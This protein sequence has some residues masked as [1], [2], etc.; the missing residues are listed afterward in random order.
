MTEFVSSRIGGAAMNQ[1]RPTQNEIGASG[2]IPEQW[3][4][5]HEAEL[6]P[7]L[8]GRARTLLKHGQA[9][10]IFR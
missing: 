3:T 7:D 10:D 8:K 4:A 5:Q 6:S 9:D 1:R 2:E